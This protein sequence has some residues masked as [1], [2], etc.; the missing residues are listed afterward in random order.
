MTPAMT[1]VSLACAISN[2]GSD[3]SSGEIQL[4]REQKAFVQEVVQ[5]GAC[6]PEN[7]EYLLRESQ[8]QADS[9]ELKIENVFFRPAAEQ[10]LRTELIPPTMHRKLVIMFI[11]AAGLAVMAFNQFRN[12]AML[13]PISRLRVRLT[14]S[15]EIP[16]PTNIQSAGD[17][18]FLDHIS[19]GLTYY[20]SS[21]KTFSPMLAESWSQKAD[22]T[23][24]FQLRKDLRFHDGTVITARDIVWSIK[25]HLIKKTSTHFPLWEYLVGCD[26]LKTLD[27][28]CEGL[29]QFGEEQIIFR[30]KAQTDSFFLQLASPETG[31]W[32][33][34]DMDATS[35][36]LKPTKF[37]GPY[38]VENRNE[39]QASLRRNENSLISK[40]F[41][42][43]HDRSFFNGWPLRVWISL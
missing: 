7:M 30:L 40:C 1:L 26:H 10:W 15:N 33:A 5:S 36:E 28:D 27:E 35:A 32:S 34:N 18:Y 13:K 17:W 23:Y 6:L 38:F 16:E 42:T 4:S 8:R 29:K 41:R 21:K 20:D 2:R 9:G 22:G 25:R 12:E 37:S 19:S 11:L 24:T 14:G 31:I 43:R 3:P 39:S